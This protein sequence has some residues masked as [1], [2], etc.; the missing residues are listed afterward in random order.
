MQFT[1]HLNETELQE[2]VAAY[3]EKTLNV[4]VHRAKVRINMHSCGG[5]NDPRERDYVDATVEY[6]K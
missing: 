2:A 1:A 4:K 3:V 5:S 6:T